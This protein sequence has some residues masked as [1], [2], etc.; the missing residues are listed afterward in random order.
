[1]NK[2]SCRKTAAG[3]SGLHKIM[4]NY[5]PAMKQDVVVLR[6]VGYIKGDYLSCDK[7]V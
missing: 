7:T 2:K 1:V 6:F 4:N 5:K 3:S